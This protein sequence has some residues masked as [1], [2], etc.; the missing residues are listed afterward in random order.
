[1]RERFEDCPQIGRFR[2][3][4]TTG[5][6]RSAC[7]VLPVFVTPHNAGYAVCH[8]SGGGGV[9]R[10]VCKRRTPQLTRGGGS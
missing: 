7:T 3:W 9:C 5:L 4:I 1:M 2:G 10:K 6:Q 8:Q